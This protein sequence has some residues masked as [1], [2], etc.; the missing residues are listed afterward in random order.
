[1]LNTPPCFA[2]YIVKL[3][4][5]W[6]LNDIGGLDKMHAINKEKAALIYSVIDNSD[7]YYK[8]H[9]DKKFRSIMNIPFRLPT[10]E[11]DK[12]FLNDANNTGLITLAG[13]RSVGGLRASIYNAMP[14]EGVELL[15]DFMIDFAK[16]NP[17]NRHG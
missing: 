2:I 4:T 9:A 13:H 7:G 8:T 12:K 10:D 17:N 15:R 14:R 6:L 11:L 1:M 3:V 16:N 5:E